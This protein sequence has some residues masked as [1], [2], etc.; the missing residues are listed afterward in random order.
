MFGLG[1]LEVTLCLLKRHESSP[2]WR[3]RVKGGDLAGACFA[4]PFLSSGLL[5][6]LLE[7]RASSSGFSS[8]VSSRSRTLCVSSALSV[9]LSLSVVSLLLVSSLAFSSSLGPRLNLS[10][11]VKEGLLRF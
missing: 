1:V 8:S 7:G 10:F 5:R 11:K 2:F 4:L 3:V 9:S 6:C